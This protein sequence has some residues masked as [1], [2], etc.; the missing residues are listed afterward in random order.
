M[1]VIL[2]CSLGLALW[3][4]TAILFVAFTRSWRLTMAVADR[5]PGKRAPDT[6]EHAGVE[7]RRLP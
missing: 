2:W 4:P 3:V 7:V 5:I 6:W 1:R